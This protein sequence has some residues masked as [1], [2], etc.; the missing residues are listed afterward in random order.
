MRVMCCVS[1]CYLLFRIF[2]FNVLS[3]GYV[4]CRLTVPRNRNSEHGTPTR[5]EG[6]QTKVYVRSA[7]GENK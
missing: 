7:S 1:C 2:S 3:C 5:V 4:S 6:G